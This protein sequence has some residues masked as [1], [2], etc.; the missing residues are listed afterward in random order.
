[1]KRNVLFYNTDDEQRHGRELGE[2]P[3]YEHLLKQIIQTYLDDS[4]SVVV[5]LGC[6]K[7]VLQFCHSRYV[8]IDLSYLMLKKYLK[9][10]CVQADAE[11]IPLRSNSADLI[12][13][14]ATLEHI[15][16]PERCLAEIDRILRPGGIAVLAPTWFC[17]PWLVKGLHSCRFQELSWKEKLIFLTLPIR[18]NSLSKAAFVVPKRFVRELS[19]CLRR[20]SALPFRYRRLKPNMEEYLCHDSDAFS[21]MDPHMAV[22]YYL[23]RGYEVIDGSKSWLSRIFMRDR[24]VLVRK[25]GRASIKGDL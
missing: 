1:M 25:S 21:S 3:F 16:H 4:A 13:E 20:S 19:Y 11:Y 22:L 6:G 24:P 2:L 18:D 12:F 23:S 8:G 17:R 7:G 15:P 5:E 14:V 10:R 9:K